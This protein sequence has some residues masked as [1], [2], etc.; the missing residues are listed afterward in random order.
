MPLPE[1]FQ[2]PNEEQQTPMEAKSEIEKRLG[3]SIIIYKTNCAYKHAEDIENR[4]KALVER[5]KK[6]VLKLH[7]NEN[8]VMV[9]YLRSPDELTLPPRDIYSAQDVIGLLPYDIKETI[10]NKRQKEYTKARQDVDKSNFSE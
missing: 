7:A 9:T 1:L 4:A 6:F 5:N 3:G 10:N 8:A 2:L